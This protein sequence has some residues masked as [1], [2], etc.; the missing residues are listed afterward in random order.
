LRAYE[1]INKK[2]PFCGYYAPPAAR[3]GPEYVDGDLT[4]LDEETLN[5][6]RGEK[7]KIDGMCYPPQNLP[8]N[9]QVAIRQKHADRQT[10]QNILR[11]SIAWWA[12]YEATQGFSE[13]QSYR[14]FFF[15]FGVDVAG[16]QI[17]GRPEAEELTTKI[18]RELVKYGIDGSIDAHGYSDKRPA[19]PS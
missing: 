2:C 16:A 14:R 3:S 12:G 5:T 15:K 10:A 11:N 18:N 17:L 19:T 6:L 1:R 8:W 4:E 7:A 13:S 9:I